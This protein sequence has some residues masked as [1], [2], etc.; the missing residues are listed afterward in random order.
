VA[1]LPVADEVASEVESEEALA[2]AVAEG[3][4]HSEAVRAK[5]VLLQHPRQ[6]SHKPASCP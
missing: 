6:A 2:E 1:V 4:H 5:V 3:A